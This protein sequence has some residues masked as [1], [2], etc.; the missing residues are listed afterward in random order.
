LG[1]IYVGS[2]LYIRPAS[3]RLLR[4]FEKGFER[5]FNVMSNAGEKFMKV[6]CWHMAFPD[7][8]TVLE[9]IF[10]VLPNHVGASLRVGLVMLLHENVMKP[11]GSVVNVVILHEPTAWSVASMFSIQLL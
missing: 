1:V 8:G 5:S 10:S 4:L 11:P 6:V 9:E 7:F 3:I 2:C